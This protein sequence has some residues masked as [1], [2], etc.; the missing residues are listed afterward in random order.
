M[1]ASFIW[2]DAF[3]DAL[4]CGVR[5]FP[6]RFYCLSNSMQ[7]RLAIE[8]ETSETKTER[9]PP[10]QRKKKR[11]SRT[12]IGIHAPFGS[13]GERFLNRYG[14]IVLFVNR[15]VLLHSEYT[16]NS[17]VAT[18]KTKLSFSVYLRIEVVI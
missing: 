17:L 1:T 14:P 8:R 16:E 4:G 18:Y 2:N 3:P 12:I 13:F 10:K 7:R 15:P 9:L 11:K 5:V 6:E